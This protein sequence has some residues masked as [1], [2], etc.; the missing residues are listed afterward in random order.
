MPKPATCTCGKRLSK[1]HW[2]YRNGGY[3]C[4]RR[5]FEEAQAK[6]AQ[7]KAAKAA[8]QKPAQPA[9]AKPEPKTEKAASQPAASS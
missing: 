1:K 9:E 2:Y 6:A 3:Y 5:C 4:K 8:E 7:D